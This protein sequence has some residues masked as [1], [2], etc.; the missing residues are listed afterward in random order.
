[1][2]AGKEINPKPSHVYG[3]NR[4]LHNTFKLYN[5]ELITFSLYDIQKINRG[6]KIVQDHLILSSPGINKFRK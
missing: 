6:Y 3:S 2:S 5:K 1:M 4:C